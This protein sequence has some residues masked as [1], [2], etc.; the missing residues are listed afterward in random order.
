VLSTR[1]ERERHADLARIVDQIPTAGDPGSKARLFTTTTV[2]TYP[3][4]AAAFY[5]AN[6]TEIDGTETEGGAASYTAD[7][8][9]IVFILNVGTAIPPNGTRVLASAVGGR[10]TFRYDG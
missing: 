6:P 1:I 3:T 2:T 7:T 5:A 10:W 8:N 4:S 9:Q